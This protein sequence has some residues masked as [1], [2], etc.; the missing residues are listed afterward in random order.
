MDAK[1]HILQGIFIVPPNRNCTAIVKGYSFV[2]IAL[3]ALGIILHIAVQKANLFSLILSERVEK[4]F[5]PPK[6]YE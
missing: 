3:E 2:K 1:F 4:L 6:G 5:Y